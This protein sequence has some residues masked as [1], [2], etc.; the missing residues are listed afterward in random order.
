MTLSNILA[1]D[2]Y[3]TVALPR[4]RIVKDHG[5]DRMKLRAMHVHPFGGVDAQEYPDISE[6]IFDSERQ[7]LDAEKILARLDII[8]FDVLKSEQ[9]LNL[10][11][12]S[13]KDIFI[14]AI[15]ELFLYIIPAISFLLSLF[16][17][18]IAYYVIVSGLASYAVPAGI[19]AF[20]FLV[21]SVVRIKIDNLKYTYS[22]NDR[23]HS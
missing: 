9:N 7:I 14:S 12:V 10:L 8:N 16:C 20:G 19:A 13:E 21:F 11:T 22:S 17:V 3:Q 15:K 1:L 18:F 23:A 5:R 6:L 4:R 2:Q